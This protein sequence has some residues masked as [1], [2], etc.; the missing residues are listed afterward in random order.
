MLTKIKLDKKCNEEK[1]EAGF[2]IEEWKHAGWRDGHEAAS[3]VLVRRA[4]N[5]VKN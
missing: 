1:L 4:L 2:S 3:R 5:S